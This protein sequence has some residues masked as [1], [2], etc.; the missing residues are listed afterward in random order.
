MT[1]RSKC[2]IG[3]LGIFL[4]GAAWAAPPRPA[5]NQADA[6]SQIRAAIADAMKSGKRIVLDFSADWC[7]DCHVLQEQ[8]EKPE[9]AELIRKNFVVVHVDVGRFDKNLDLAAQYDVPLRQGIP[10]LAVLDEHGKLLYSQ[11]KGQFQDARHLNAET[12]KAFFEKWKP[13]R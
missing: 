11:E 12:I 4:A 9:L 8:M 7:F 3:I 5:E 13:A 6:H 10:A 2:A 1:A